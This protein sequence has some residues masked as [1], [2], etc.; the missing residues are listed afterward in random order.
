M[1]FYQDLSD[2]GFSNDPI[3]NILLLVF[4]LLYTKYCNNPDKANLSVRRGQKAAGLK[5][6]MAELPREI[7]LVSS[8]FFIY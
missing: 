7:P 3:D 8:V 6:K 4:N 2:S 1:N 5:N